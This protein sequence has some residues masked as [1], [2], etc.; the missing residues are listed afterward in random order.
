M[1]AAVFFV[2]AEL[3]HGFAVLSQEE[4]RVITKTAR[5]AFFGDDLS[6]TVAF[7]ELESRT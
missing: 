1:A 4:D 7:E 3:G 2:D 6:F 5:T